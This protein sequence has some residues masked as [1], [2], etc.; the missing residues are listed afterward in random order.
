MCMCAHMQNSQSLGVDDNGSRGWS[1][2][3]MPCG[4]GRLFKD[5][6]SQQQLANVSLGCET[7]HQGCIPT[8]HTGI[9]KGPT[10]WCSALSKDHSSC[11]TA[12]WAASIYEHFPQSRLCPDSSCLT[13]PL[14][15]GLPL[16]PFCSHLTHP[17]SILVTRR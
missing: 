5:F 8:R 17:H 4:P 16:I 14:Q 11:L 12:I 7:C 13:H 10:G 9:G 15:G 2:G 1:R 6:S 3:M